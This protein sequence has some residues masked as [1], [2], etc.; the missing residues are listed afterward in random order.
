MEGELSHLL[1]RSPLRFNRFFSEKTGGRS[2]LGPGFRRH[3]GQGRGEGRLPPSSPAPGMSAE[4]VA[5]ESRDY[6]ARVCARRGGNMAIFFFFF[7]FFNIFLLIFF[8][9]QKTQPKNHPPPQKKKKKP[10]AD[11]VPCPPASPRARPWGTCNH[12]P[13]PAVPPPPFLLRL[14]H[15]L[16][17]RALIS[18]NPP[19]RK[20]AFCLL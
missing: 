17:H 9:L 5:M 4:H 10:F 11:G 19:P 20:R 2:G 3:R 13:I 12:L 15:Q 16:L 6:S 1:R 8:F 7:L 14:L 18:N